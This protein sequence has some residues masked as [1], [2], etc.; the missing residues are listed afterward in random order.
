MVIETEVNSGTMHTVEFALRQYKRLACY[1]YQFMN[2]N[3]SSGNKYLE[4]AGKATILK[5][6]DDLTH[7]LQ[8]IENIGNYEQLSLF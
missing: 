1:Y 4:E 2:M 7:F 6:K 5:S 3:A 8:T